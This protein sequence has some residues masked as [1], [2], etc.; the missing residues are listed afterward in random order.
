MAGAATSE[1]MENRPGMEADG[2][3]MELI[4][5][6]CAFSTARV[7]ANSRRMEDM[8]EVR[9]IVHLVSVPYFRLWKI[10]SSTTAAWWRGIPRETAGIL[11][12]KDTNP[13][14]GLCV[15]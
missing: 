7:P 14:C 8:P 6:D 2:E 13:H 4:F 15:W 10:D 12:C 11:P 1:I 9:V 5:N 3:G